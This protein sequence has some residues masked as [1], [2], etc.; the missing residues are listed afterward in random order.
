[1]KHVRLHCSSLR[2]LRLNNIPPTLLPI[3]PATVLSEDCIFK[4][5]PKLS[6]EGTLGNKS[7]IGVYGCGDVQTAIA[8]VWTDLQDV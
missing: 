2:E 3:H 5:I 1:M 4:P 6:L 8:V 7:A